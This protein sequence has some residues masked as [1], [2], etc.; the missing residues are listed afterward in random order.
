MLILEADHTLYHSG[1]KGM[2]WGVH[3]GALV[4]RQSMLTKNRQNSIDKKELNSLEKNLGRGSVHQKNLDKRKIE[5]LKKGQKISKRKMSDLEK[6]QTIN[7]LK[8]VGKRVAISLG[9]LGSAVISSALA[10]R[11]VEKYYARQSAEAIAKMLLNRQA[12]NIIYLP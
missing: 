4:R 11:A 5:A 6:T 7:A 1:V 10:Q 9:I 12:R 3:K 8:D 2:K